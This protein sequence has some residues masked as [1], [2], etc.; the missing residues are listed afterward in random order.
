MRTSIRNLIR[1]CRKGT[2]EMFG[3]AIVTGM[4]TL[5][6]IF[7]VGL[8]SMT[9]AERSMDNLMQQVCRNAATYPTLYDA[10]DYAKQEI[11]DK[12]NTSLVTIDRVEIDYETPA[13]VAGYASGDLRE[14]KKGNNVIIT[15]EYT[16]ISTMPSIT[17]H[18][19]NT[20]KFMIEYNPEVSD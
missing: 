19:T 15:V 13:S 10:E 16:V 18:R 9:L 3:S 5:I 17:A 2:L 20:Q 14:W 6:F 4:L 12:C 7:S 1:K 8:F 11:I